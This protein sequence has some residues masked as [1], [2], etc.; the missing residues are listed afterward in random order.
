MLQINKSYKGLS[1]ICRK[2]IKILSFSLFLVG[3]AVLCYT[4]GW[5]PGIMLAIGLPL[6]LKQYL[7][8]KTYD[9]WITLFV[10]LGIFT[11]IS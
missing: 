11:N 9:T 6:A 3:V 5:W 1:M 7:L 2:K 4:G 10:F 8:G